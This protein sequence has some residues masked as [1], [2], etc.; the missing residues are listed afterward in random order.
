MLPTACPRPLKGSGQLARRARR[1]EDS[2]ALA[3][4]YAVVDAR[5]G[6]FCV[7]TGRFVVAGAVDPRRRREHHHLKG[8]NVRPDWVTDP[9]RII[10]VAADVHQLIEG[11][12]IEV[13]GENANQRIVAH[14]NRALMPSGREPFRLLSRRWSM[15]EDWR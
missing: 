6:G 10:T 14:W 5:D 7:I 1:A 9:R 15:Q 8:R 13:E 3:D 2:T 4:A 12:F 11:G